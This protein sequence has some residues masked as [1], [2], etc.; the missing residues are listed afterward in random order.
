MKISKIKFICRKKEKG[1]TLVELVITLIVIIILMSVSIPLYRSNTDNFKLAEGY[2]LLA[3][4]RSAQER[5]YSEY[6]CFLISACGSGGSGRDGDSN[7]YATCNEE[8]LGV[9]ARMNKYFSLFCIDTSYAVGS[10]PF[11]PVRDKEHRFKAMVTS[12]DSSFG[13]YGK[14]MILDYDLTCTVKYEIF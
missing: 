11:S 7:P 10:D 2:A 12:R 13:N 9:N 5:Y 14:R 4:I 1:F 3:T 6:G 8:V